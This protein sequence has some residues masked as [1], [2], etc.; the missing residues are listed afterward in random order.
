MNITRRGIT[1]RGMTRGIGLAAAAAVWGWGAHTAQAQGVLEYGSENLLGT[2]TYSSD[3]KAGATLSGLTAGMI[4]E[5]NQYFAH[6]FPFSPSA[7]DYPGTD[8]I[9][10][11]TNQ[12]AFHDGYSQYSGRISGPQ[13]ISMN[14]GSLVP[15][16]QQVQT[17]TLGIDADDFQ[18][19]VFGDPFSATLNGVAMPGLSAELNSF[20]E[21][22][23][24]THFFTFGVDPSLLSSGS[25]L[26]LS[27]NEGGDGGDGWAIDF[28]T[29]GV[30]TAPAA[31]PEASTSLAFG[32]LLALG[33]GGM[34]FRARR[35]AQY[36]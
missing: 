22:G 20:N 6:G 3:P 14:Y 34:T 25:N 28:L 33:L 2:G 5:A 7:G 18:N 26:V 27:I 30:T 24:L 8:Q 31:V 15:A 12:T 17:L 23:P 32:M 13:V 4:T 29:V 1:R 16:G 35:K 19:A 36:M 10:V 9:Y 21:T 11:G